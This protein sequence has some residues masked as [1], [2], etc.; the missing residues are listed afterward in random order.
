MGVISEWDK[1]AD[2]ELLGAA[3]A[4]A[5]DY[6]DTQVSSLSGVMDEINAKIDEVKAITEQAKSA[7]TNAT[8]A[9]N[10]AKAAA[11]AAKSV[12]QTAANNASSIN[13]IAGSML[14]EGKRLKAYATLRKNET[15]TALSMKNILFDTFS[16]Q[17][18]A[19]VDIT[20]GCEYQF[21]LEVIING[22]TIY[23]GNISDKVISIPTK[24]KI[25]DL[26]IKVTGNA[27]NYGNNVG[28]LCREYEYYIEY[29]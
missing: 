17:Y 2:V 9:A 27:S 13:K 25:N 12:A 5:K 11:D 7:A 19:F 1:A 18:P 21:M 8:T 28:I 23:S 20:I 4:N 15:Y 22:I 26:V 6:T 16:G 10:N 14:S 29:N 24:I 3:Q